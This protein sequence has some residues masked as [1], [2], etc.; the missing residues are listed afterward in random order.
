MIYRISNYML[1]NAR[2]NSQYIFGEFLVGV[3]IN[4]RERVFE[5][6]L[7]KTLKV[8]QEGKIVEEKIEDYVDLERYRK[9][10]GPQWKLIFSKDEDVF[11][12]N[13]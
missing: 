3:K 2:K 9:F 7:H 1:A 10:W 12:D 5:I 6:R 13:N 11:N 8:K 4:E